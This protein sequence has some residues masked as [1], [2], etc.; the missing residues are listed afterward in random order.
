MGAD[1]VFCCTEPPRKDAKSAFAVV[2]AVNHYNIVVKAA[3]FSSQ[4]RKEMAVTGGFLAYS[5]ESK[6][7]GPTS[8]EATSAIFKLFN[9]RL[10]APY[11]ILFFFFFFFHS[12][13]S[14][15]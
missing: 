13:Y 9:L 6:A 3:P 2:A 10:T 11:Y 12:A 1:D 4:I 14:D 5:A 15:P 7:V 8:F